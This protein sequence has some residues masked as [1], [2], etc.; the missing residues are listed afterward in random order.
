MKACNKP[1]MKAVTDD[2]AS[3]GS[4]R[5]FP[6]EVIDSLMDKVRVHLDDGD[7]KKTNDKALSKYIKATAGRYRTEVVNCKFNTTENK[8]RVGMAKTTHTKEHHKKHNEKMKHRKTCCAHVIFPTVETTC[9]RSVRQYN[10]LCDIHSRAL[11]TAVEQA[12][13]E[14]DELDEQ[15]QLYAKAAERNNNLKRRS[16]DMQNTHRAKKPKRE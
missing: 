10:M 11:N 15:Q 6:D 2:L 1:I 12:D 5:L 9:K 14:G 16:N 4:Y 3:H 7:E 8:G 13:E